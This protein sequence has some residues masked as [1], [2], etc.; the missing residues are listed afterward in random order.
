M[1]AGVWVRTNMRVPL[2]EKIHMSIRQLCLKAIILDTLQ[3]TKE[4]KTLADA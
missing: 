4:K 3:E 2:Y 1:F